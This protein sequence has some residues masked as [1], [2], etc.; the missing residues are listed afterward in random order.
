MHEVVVPLWRNLVPFLVLF[1]CYC[2][3]PT[4]RQRYTWKHTHTDGQKHT[5]TTHTCTYT[6]T[7]TNHTAY[8]HTTHT[9]THTHI[10]THTQTHTHTHTDTHTHTKL[11]T[12]HSNCIHFSSHS[13][14]HKYLDS[15]TFDILCFTYLSKKIWKFDITTEQKRN[16][17]TSRL[18]RNQLFI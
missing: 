6:Y 14:C 5:Q 4:N 17:S 8:P 15:E 16:K 11:V 9:H 12:V 1:R 10:H 7:H 13:P 3:S 2:H 18:N